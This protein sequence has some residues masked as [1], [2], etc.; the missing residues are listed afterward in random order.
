MDWCLIF[1]VKANNIHQT[2]ISLLD[3]WIFLENQ[4]IYP[5]KYYLRIKQ[6]KS[7]LLYIADFR[8]VR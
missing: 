7:V 2:Q 1:C 5:F 6:S 8:N 4:W 3:L